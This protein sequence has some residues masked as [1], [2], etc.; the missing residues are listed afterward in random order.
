MTHK[1][2]LTRSVGFYL[3]EGFWA[4]KKP[5][6]SKFNSQYWLKPEFWK[7]MEEKIVQVKHDSAEIVVYRDGLVTYT[8]GDLSAG[9]SGDETFKRI[10]KY[11]EILNAIFAVFV[12]TFTQETKV[13][14]HTNFEVTH[15]QI[16]PLT[17]ENGI[18]VGMGIPQKS[19][20]TSQIDKRYLMNVPSGYEDSLD[21]WLDRPT[22]AIIPKAVIEK[23]CNTFFVI[24]KD[25]YSTRILARSNKAAAEY[26]STSFSDC[27]LVSWLQV[28]VYLHTKLEQYMKKEGSTKF[29]KKRRDGLKKTTSAQVIELLEVSGNLSKDVY[30]LLAKVRKVRNDIVHNNYSASVQEAND[31]LSLLEQTIAETSGESVKLN[32]GITMSLF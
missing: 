23:A 31:A 7:L 28:E 24:A 16:V 1:P 15:H 3:I 19:T 29:N 30:D 2:V 21:D 10:E 26:A 22:R 5:D 20:T 12:S 18:Q 17:F 6:Y 27:I 25:K 11:T 8:D 4:D 32:T 13:K 14:Y 9:S